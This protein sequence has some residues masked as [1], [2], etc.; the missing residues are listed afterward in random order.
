MNYEPHEID[1]GGIFK[2]Q[3]EKNAQQTLQR[4]SGYKLNQSRALKAAE[5]GNHNKLISNLFNNKKLK[6][7]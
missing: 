6:L 1:C 3:R 5:N 7:K 2:W 4:K